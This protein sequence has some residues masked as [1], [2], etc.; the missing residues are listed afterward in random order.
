M[1]FRDL[2]TRISM[3]YPGRTAAQ[4]CALPAGGQER[5]RHFD[6][7]SFEPRKCPKTRTPRSASPTTM[8]PMLFGDR[9]HAV[10]LEYNRKGRGG[11]ILG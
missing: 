6:G 7:A 1:R 4:R 2:L 11:G 9:V 5:Q 10:L 8:A 3:I